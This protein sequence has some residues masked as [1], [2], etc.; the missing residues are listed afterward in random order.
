MAT[1]WVGVNC[2]RTEHVFGCSIISSHK[3]MFGAKIYSCLYTR[4]CYYF[5]LRIN[6]Q[7]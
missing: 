5:L 6:T 7:T 1:T 2:C 3:N 4:L